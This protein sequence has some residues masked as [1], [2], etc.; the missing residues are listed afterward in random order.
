M[1]LW[2]VCNPK[3]PPPPAPG[4]LEVRKGTGASDTFLLACAALTLY[5]LGSLLRHDSCTGDKRP[6]VSWD[7]K[8]VGL[9]PAVSPFP[10]LPFAVW[11]FHGPGHFGV[12][13]HFSGGFCRND[14]SDYT[15]LELIIL[16][17]FFYCYR[18]MDDVRHVSDSY[19]RFSVFTILFLL[20]YLRKSLKGSTVSSS[21][22]LDMR[23]HSLHVYI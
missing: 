18:Q 3:L 2:Y 15:Y 10:P 19:L 8:A 17:I 20:S 11:I 21:S 4:W 13:G 14:L 6:L 1:F 5:A 9:N 22:N 7:G 12:L 23:Q 16:F